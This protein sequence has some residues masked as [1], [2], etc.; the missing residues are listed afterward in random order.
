MV[1]YNVIII[2]DLI[3]FNSIKPKNQI[4][5]KLKKNKRDFWSFASLTEISSKIMYR[6]VSQPLVEQSIVHS[7]SALERLQYFD[8]ISEKVGT[9]VS[10]ATGDK[11]FCVVGTKDSFDL[12]LNPFSAFI[13]IT[14]NQLEVVLFRIEKVQAQFLPAYELDDH[15][16]DPEVDD[17]EYLGLDARYANLL[18][19]KIIIW[20]LTFNLFLF[21]LLIYYKI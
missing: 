16:V 15:H 11:W 19:V 5:G 9:D 1:S 20:L 8:E 21:F 18:I 2:I 10:S 17:Q 4:S 13:V 3:Q 6:N 14:V 7:V 12:N